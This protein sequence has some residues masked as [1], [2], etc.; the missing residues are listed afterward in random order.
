M[1]TRHAR[2]LLALPAIAATLLLAGCERP[3][4]Q[5]SQ[6]GYRGTGME[7]VTNP[8]IV[9]SEAA[10]HVAPAPIDPVD[11]GGPKA[12]DVYQN[13]KVLGDLGIGEFNRLMVAMTQWVAP[14][15]SCG[16]CH[17]LQNLADDSLY[18]KNTARKMLQMT[19]E[20]N[21]RWKAHVADTG[22][23]CYTCHRGQPVPAERWFADPPASTAGRMLGND[24]GQNKAGKASVVNASL[25]YD[26]FTPFLLGDKEIRV[27][28]KTALPTGHDVPLKQAEWTHGLMMHMSDG[29]GVGC[30]HCH[31]SRAFAEWNQSPPAR[32]TA[33]HGIRMVRDL[34]NQFMV[35]LTP[36]QPKERLG[37]TGDIAKV[38]CAT[39][40]QGV[41]RPLNG[42]NMVK[43]HPELMA[44]PRPAAKTSQ[45]S[46]EGLLGAGHAVR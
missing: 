42:A 17:N 31:N 38:N 35:P 7:Q 18:T 41:N 45:L 37:R 22:V 12:R 43:A 10:R 28:A 2:I 24:N 5:T 32:I 27:T 26:P 29:L 46:T 44:P 6:I 8:R 3:D 9:A 14:E 16:Y 25:P 40:H 39:C 21:S 11:A 34:N 36:G 4:M 33:W 19:W 15:Q 23:T 30:V 20:I 1:M 13:V